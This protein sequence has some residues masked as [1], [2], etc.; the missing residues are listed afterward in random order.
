MKRRPRVAV[1][2]LVCCLLL[3]ATAFSAPQASDSV[4]FET[5]GSVVAWGCGGDY[6]YRQCDVPASATRGVKAIAANE[7]HSL[8]RRNDSSV[9]AWGCYGYGAGECDVPVAA[10]RGVIA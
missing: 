7:F 5:D 9:V 2:C 4:G 10:R 3:L 8:A 1:G 6:D